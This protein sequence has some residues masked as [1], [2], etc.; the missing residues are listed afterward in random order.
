MSNSI[1]QAMGGNLMPGPMGNMQQMVQQFR[2]FKQNFQ[3]DPRQVVQQML[4]SGQ[5]TQTQLNQAQAMAQ[6]V[7]QF[8]K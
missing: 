5:I 2:Q 6:Q 8:L 1:F 3:G 4:Q 7:A